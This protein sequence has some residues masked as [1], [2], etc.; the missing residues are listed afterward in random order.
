MNIR[1]ATIAAVS[2][3]MGLL[4]AISSEAKDT[5]SEDGLTVSHDASND[6][7]F[8]WTLERMLLAVPMPMTE[9]GRKFMNTHKSLD[10]IRDWSE[11]KFNAYLD[12]D[13]ARTHV[14]EEAVR[15]RDLAKMLE[16]Q[17]TRGSKLLE[18]EPPVIANSPVFP[19]AN[20][21]SIDDLRKM[22]SGTSVE[23]SAVLSQMKI[24]RQR[25]ADLAPQVEAIRK[26]ASA[27]GLSQKLEEVMTPE[28]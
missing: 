11:G 26:E 3:V 8:E 20:Q 24:W 5:I 15:W 25:I 10:S 1:K 18:K 16:G 27:K 9:E 2:V 13:Y 4:L 19:S 23:R 12:S 17:A 22:L 28:Q 6:P 7:A 14:A 21:A